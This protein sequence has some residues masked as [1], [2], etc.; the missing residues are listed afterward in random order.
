MKAPQN[1]S[2]GDGLGVRVGQHDAGVVAAELQ[3]QALHGVRGGSDDGLAGGGGAGEHDLVDLRVG[4]QGLADVAAAGDHVQHVGR[5]HR[6]EHVRQRQHGQRGVLG[7]LHD[8]GVAHP[9]RR[10]EL[11]DGDHHRPVPRPDRADDAEGPVVQ[12]G[13]AALVV[14]QDLRLELEGRGGAQPGRARADLE[15]GVG[16]VQRLALLAGEQHRERLGACLDGVGG[17][18]ERGGPGLVAQ[19]SP[20]R[21]SGPGCVDGVLEVCDCVYR[22]F[23]DRLSGGR[24]EDG[25]GGDCVLCQD[26]CGVHGFLNLGDCGLEFRGGWTALCR[27]SRVRVLPRR[28]CR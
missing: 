11:P 8:H 19:G 13:A 5:Q 9:Q 4:G 20:C 6:V 18:Q 10:G 28:R 7:G 24:V 23:A 25:A 3:G 16:A 27:L 17:F 15:A 2:C 26:S 21:L 1:R 14:D 12:L 22:C